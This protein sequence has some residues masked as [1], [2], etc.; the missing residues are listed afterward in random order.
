[1]SL[2]SLV[3]IALAVAAVA[4][5]L[6][7]TLLQRGARQAA[8][9]AATLTDT[10][11]GGYYF[12]DTR[13]GRER[14]S[15]GLATTLGAG[16]GPLA[17]FADLAPCFDEAD[18]A[19]LTT[20]IGALRGQDSEFTARLAAADG[21][22]EFAANGQTV[23]DGGGRKLGFIVWLRDVDGTPGSGE[24]TA[25][26][27]RSEFAQILDT[28]LLPVW[29]RNDSPDIVWWNAAFADAVG[30]ATDTARDRDLFEFSSL[31]FARRANALA[32]SARAANGVASEVRTLVVDGERRSFEVVEQPVEGGM[33]GVARNITESTRADDELERHIA[34]HAAVLEQLG[35][36]S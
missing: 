7:A 24:G 25:A 33:I 8:G 16:D 29:R 13:G 31:P 35:R 12:W 11:P 1:M 18:Y 5:G 15:S 32:E 14:A 34:A 36:R 4:A 3:A 17:A 20:L 22:R 10:A 23:R 27:S 21:N 6:V 26:A 2:A 19:R 30:G 28:I 9:L